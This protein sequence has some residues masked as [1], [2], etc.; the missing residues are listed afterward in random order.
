M[1]GVAVGTPA[2]LS[3]VGT[4]VAVVASMM[5]SKLVFEKA[6]VVSLTSWMSTCSPAGS[7]DAEALYQQ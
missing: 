3:D 1:M 7:S 4:P 6:A 5:M 2:G